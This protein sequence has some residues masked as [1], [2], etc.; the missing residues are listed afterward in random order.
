[1]HVQARATPATS[2]ADVE[3]FLK[4]LSEPEGLTD[5]GRPRE[6]INIEGVTG[7]DLEGKGKIVFSFDHDRE[8]DVARWLREAGYK[9]VT[10]LNADEGQIFWAE[11]S[12]NAPGQLLDAIRAGKGANSGKRIRDV[13]I[14][15]ETQ[16]PNRFYVHISFE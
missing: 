9:D 14:G 3:A 7:T 16:K 5:E 11:L 15:Q 8:A 2:P 4:V 1:M 6:P 12:G 13:L 10:F